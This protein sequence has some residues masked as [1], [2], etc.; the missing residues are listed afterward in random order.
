MR[1]ILLTAALTFACGGDKSK[2]STEEAVP[3]QP[4]PAEEP[5]AVA[6]PADAGQTAPDDTCVSECIA[7]RQMQATSPEQIEIDCKKRCGEE[8]P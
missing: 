4:I 3:A 2:P 1:W 7:S 6:A 8:E 5:A